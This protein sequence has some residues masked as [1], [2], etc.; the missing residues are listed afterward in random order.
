MMISDLRRFHLTRVTE[1]I[2]DTS[3]NES[4]SV[5]WR[6]LQDSRAPHVRDTEGSIRVEFLEHLVC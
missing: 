3:K 2:R 4:A 6:D 5:R 1:E